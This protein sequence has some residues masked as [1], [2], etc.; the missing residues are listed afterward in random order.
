MTSSNNIISLRPAQLIARQELL[1]LFDG[2]EHHGGALTTAMGGGKTCVVCSFIKM[3]IDRLEDAKAIIIVPLS[4]INVWTKEWR[5]IGGDPHVINVYH[6]T[7]R[8]MDSSTARVIISTVGTLRSD[9]KRRRYNVF[10]PTYVVAAIDEGH[11]M[12]NLALPVTAVGE[13]RATVKMPLY[14]KIFDRLKYSFGLPITGTPFMNCH[15]DLRSLL[16]M[17]KRPLACTTDD[18]TITSTFKIQEVHSSLSSM[19]SDM[20][21][22]Q[23]TEHTLEFTTPEEKKNA[24]KLHKTIIILSRRMAALRSQGRPVPDQLLHRYFLAKSHAKLHS[25]FGEKS[26]EG[27]R[28][29]TTDQVRTCPK[30]KKLVA[31]MKTIFDES[32]TD[33]IGIVSRYTSVLDV[34][35]RLIDEDDTLPDAVYY[36]GGLRSDDRK[37]VISKYMNRANNVRIILLSMDASCVGLNLRGQHQILLDPG[38]N[39]GTEAQVNC[40]FR[41]LGQSGIVQVARYTMDTG[42]DQMTKNAKVVKLLSSLKVDP[43][44]RIA[45]QTVY[46]MTDEKIDQWLGSHGPNGRRLRSSRRRPAAAVATAVVATT[47]ITTHGRSGVDHAIDGRVSKRQRS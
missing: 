21:T 22:L 12:A 36:H 45:L 24:T 26:A 18:A 23:H 30:G 46:K 40:R 20:P 38:T 13:A 10:E 41:R 2:E 37:D 5:R 25:I 15:R 32:K 44:A 33:T 9:I 31:H 4:T 8:T 3:I 28:A 19:A 27:T 43:L 14:A 29:M 34:V 16:V 47:T 6:G 42:V 17:M 11:T 1:D 7:K 35:K 39:H